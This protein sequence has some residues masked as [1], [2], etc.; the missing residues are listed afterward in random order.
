MT[1]EQIISELKKLGN[2][3]NLEGM[4]RFGINPDFAIGISIKNL[5]E[6]A[7]HL[8]HNHQLALDLWGSG[9]HEAR[10]LASILD[11]PKQVTE[12]QMDDWAIKFNSWDLCDQC[13]NNL[14]R[15]TVY[16][17]DKALEW[18]FRDETFV[19]RA[20]FTLM[21]VSA[22][23]RKEYSDD[24]FYPFF[25]RIIAESGDE[26][27]FVKKSVNWA[28]RQI[29]KRNITLNNRAVE[30]SAQLAEYN[31]NSARWIGKDAYR[32]LTN[33]KINDTLKN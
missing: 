15:K 10:I 31:S 8:P 18:S 5:R 11:I 6:A 13:C 16:S 26:R 27:N 30:I 1:A 25:E 21:A 20:G 29:G 23:H 24:M 28:L 2:T 12:K 9:L 33:S 32:E 3:K 14:F 17:Y 4:A 7:K 19:K 22:V